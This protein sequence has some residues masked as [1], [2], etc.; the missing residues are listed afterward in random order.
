M[1]I[2]KPYVVLKESNCSSAANLDIE[3]EYSDDDGATWNLIAGATALEYDPPVITAD[4][5]YRRNLRETGCTTWYSSN[6]VEAA[7]CVVADPCDTSTNPFPNVIA[8]PAVSCPLSDPGN[9]ADIS[10]PQPDCNQVIDH[11]IDA[12]LT[13]WSLVNTSPATSTISM[14]NTG[15]LSGPNSLFL[16]QLT[17]SNIWRTTLQHPVEVEAGKTYDI[18]FEARASSSRGMRIYIQLENAP[19]TEYY[20][21]WVNLTTT[22]Q[23]YTFSGIN[24]GVTSSDVVFAFKTANSA[25]DIWFDNIHFE[26][27]GCVPSG[28]VGATYEQEWEYSDDGGVTWTVISG[29]TDLEYDPDVITA[30]RLYRRKIRGVG[31]PDWV[32]SNE[33]E[34]LLCA[35][36]DPC[37]GVSGGSILE[38][39]VACPS[40]EPGE[41]FSDTPA[42]NNCNDLEN[43][44]FDNGLSNWA[45]TSAINL[46]VDNTGLLSGP[47]SGFVNVSGSSGALYN[48]TNEFTAGELVEVSF[49]AYAQSN[50]TITAVIKQNHSPWLALWTQSV[51][52]TTCLLYTSP[53][54]RDATLSRMPS[55]A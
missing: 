35:P 11:E 48:T 31:C 42:T 37:D 54:P 1:N 41:I 7:L 4:R 3:W 49:E 52:L 32:L 53:S 9:I 24:P 15:Q 16:E 34:A 44:E 20:N 12:G 5:L 6:E 14:D 30:D 50:K 39:S 28:A 33:V 40:N 18:T 36:V 45:S 38:P 27:T 43:G 17:T 2:I 21:Q 46:S 19:H 23:T 22:A 26:E 25:H 13:N 8:S 47:N 55:S 29:A 10:S 51:S